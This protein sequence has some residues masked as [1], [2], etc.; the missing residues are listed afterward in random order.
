[1]WCVGRTVAGGGIE[2]TV[3]SM[4]DSTS[5]MPSAEQCALHKQ[6]F[7]HFVAFHCI[8]RSTLIT[9]CY[10]IIMVVN[11]AF[12]YLEWFVINVTCV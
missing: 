4:S 3:S 7:K 6:Y 1:M 11:C 10:I 9:F 8:T 12:R 5:L 2:N